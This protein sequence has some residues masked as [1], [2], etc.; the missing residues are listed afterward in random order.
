MSEIKVKMGPSKPKGAPVDP[1][2]K[3]EMIGEYLLTAPLT[4][5]NSGFSKWGFCTKDGTEYFI[6]E[7]LSPVYPDDTVNIAPAIKNRRCK[8]CNEWF[9]K[10]QV[11]YNKICEAANGNII[12]PFRFFKHNSHFYIVTDK[13]PP[14]SFEFKSVKYLPPEQKHIL[15]KVITA[16]FSS[17]ASKG[18]VHADMKPE[19]I[20][21]K[22]TL[23]YQYTAKI[24]DF[25]GSYLVTNPPFGDDV[26][27]TPEYMAPESFLVLAE[28]KVELTPKVDVFA[29]G[30]VFHEMLCGEKPTYKGDAS[31]IYEAVLKDYGI[32]L[33]PALPSGYKNIIANMLKKDAADR[34]SAAK[35]FNHLSQMTAKDLKQ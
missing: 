9:A 23:P 31:Y 7:F 25:D 33:N 1:D 30:I 26:Q 20:L 4:T 34:W 5:K 13:V 2:F 19:N 29:L 12:A 17:L 27:G 22:N 14:C 24:I 28:N 15:L 18:I 10:K 32:V 8:E 35:V 11:I 16:C 6:K 3:P 21:F